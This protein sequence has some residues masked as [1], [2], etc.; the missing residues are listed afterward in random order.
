MVGQTLTNLAIRE[1]F[2][3]NIALI[4]RGK[5]SI[6]TPG[7]NE[8]LYPY[9]KLTVIGNDEQIARLKEL[10]EVSHDYSESSSDLRDSLEL[11]KISI[12]SQSPLSGQTIRASGLRE[13]VQGLIV[14]IE[15]LEARI[16]NPESDFI[17]EPG[18]VM[19]I[20]GNKKRISEMLQK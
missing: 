8:S 14:G 18:D 10:L 9:D 11:Q 15:R 12:S 3:V 7:R 5:L 1:Q 17:F 16:L 4:E 2:G 19:W 13:K 6:A 20:V